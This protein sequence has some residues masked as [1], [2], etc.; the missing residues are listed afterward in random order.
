LEV[1]GGEAW[2]QMIVL[3]R[4]DPAAVDERFL[5]PKPV[6]DNEVKVGSRW[7][8]NQAVIAQHR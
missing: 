2:A 7:I 6:L 8:A 4:D 1:R 5:G 3:N